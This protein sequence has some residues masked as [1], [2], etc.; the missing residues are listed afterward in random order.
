MLALVLSCFVG[1]P[2]PTAPQ[3]NVF[4]QQAAQQRA[5]ARHQ[6]RNEN[7]TDDAT[8]GSDEDADEDA[9]LLVSNVL[10]QKSKALSWR[11]MLNRQGS[12]LEG[13][14][15]WELC[16]YC[17]MCVFTVNLKTIFRY[18]H[19]TVDPFITFSLCAR[20][21][22]TLPTTGTLR[23]AYTVLLCHSSAVL[24]CCHT[25]LPCCLSCCHT[26]PPCH[27]AVSLPSVFRAVV[28]VP[29]ESGVSK[30]NAPQNTGNPAQVSDPRVWVWD[31]HWA[32]L[33]HQPDHDPA[34]G[35]HCGSRH[36]QLSPF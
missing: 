11:R 16:K 31:P 35:A 22:H 30:I 29:K 28:D 20:G 10:P 33:R 5:G 9:P 3:P 12:L 34:A 7:G 14:D 8:E 19:F 6:R 15:G 23:S 25:Q 27:A 1:D 21:F 13:I 17:V 2:R 32:D 36:Q 4:A 26:Q 18:G 24:S